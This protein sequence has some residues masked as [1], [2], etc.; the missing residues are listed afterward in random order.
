MHF[1]YT[2]QL[3]AYLGQF[4][5]QRIAATYG[6]RKAAAAGLSPEVHNTIGFMNLFGKVGLPL[7][8]LVW[9]VTNQKALLAV[10]H[11]HLRLCISWFD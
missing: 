3:F 7:D 5:R 8:S 10:S 1:R 2:T 6:D 4:V 11:V 9:S